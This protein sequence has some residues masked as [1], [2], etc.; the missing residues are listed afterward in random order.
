MY[1]T[2]LFLYKQKQ[3]ILHDA[4]EL[5]NKRWRIVYAKNLKLSR[6]VDNTIRFEFLNQD[7]KPIMLNDFIFVMKILDRDTNEIL[8]SKQLEIMDEIYGKAKVII[9]AQELDH[10]KPQI[11]HYTM[12]IYNSNTGLTEAVYIDE[13]A[14]MRGIIEILDA[15]YPSVLASKSL[16]TPAW[17]IDNS[18]AVY[19]D[20]WQSTQYSQTLQ[21]STNLF[22][23]K[24]IIQ[25][26]DISTGDWMDI[27]TIE[28]L[29]EDTNTHYININGWYPNLRIKLEWITGN[30]TNILVR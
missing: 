14:G 21:Y 10:I 15:I 24:L 9:R 25:T 13:Q 6:G 7:Q 1:S 12:S 17:P 29:T 3:K 26:S 28:F 22:T 11:G 5:S 4:D 19:S 27:Q 30:I 18:V 20:I 23:G 8:L 16:N 2:A